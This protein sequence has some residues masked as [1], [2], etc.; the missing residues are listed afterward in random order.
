M[1]ETPEQRTHRELAELMIG[2]SND[3]KVGKIVKR[4]ITEL[5]PTRRF[6]D[7]EADDL[8]AELNTFKAETKAER[9]QEKAL[10]RQEA[11]R[12]ALTSRYGDEDI[13]K[14]E[15]L[16]TANGLGDYELGARLYAAETTPARPTHET[17][18]QTWKAPSIKL[19]ELDNLNNSTLDKAYAV[20]DQLRGRNVH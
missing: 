18:S 3:E 16:M 1:A 14:I 20:V 5:N 4:R 6:A 11:A 7:V 19:N 10:A 13:A 15:E 17:K 12:H 2:L 8:R 9:D